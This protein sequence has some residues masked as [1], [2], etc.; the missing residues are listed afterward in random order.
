MSAFDRDDVDICVAVVLGAEGDYLAIG[1]KRRAGF[2]AFVGSQSPDF[3]A[4]DVRHP[5][6]AGINESDVS[7]ADG[8]L[9]CARSRVSFRFTPPWPNRRIDTPQLMRITTAAIRA[10]LFME[11]P[12]NLHSHQRGCAFLQSVQGV[13]LPNFAVPQG[14]STYLRDFRRSSSKGTLFS[15]AHSITNSLWASS[16]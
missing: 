6:I 15:L 2:D 7:P 5:E 10:R 14:E 3:R 13:V 12:L 11:P 1:R 16:R 9:A 8:R 4:V